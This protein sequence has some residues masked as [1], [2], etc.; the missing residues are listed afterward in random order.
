MFEKTKINEK[1]AGVGPFKKGVNVTLGIIINDIKTNSSNIFCKQRNFM[2]HFVASILKWAAQ[3]C[4]F[5]L[6]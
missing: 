2:F 4:K 3:N 5:L 6:F 1:E